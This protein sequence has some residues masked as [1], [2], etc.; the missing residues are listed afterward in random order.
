MQRYNLY[1]KDIQR[2]IEDIEKSVKE[3][4]ISTFSKSRDTIDSNA[5]RIQI[6]GESLKNLPLNNWGNFR[7]DAK[8]FIDFRNIISHAYFK[9]N[10]HILWDIIKN[11][12]PILKKQIGIIIKEIKN[13][14]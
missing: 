11:K 10:P 4:D 12:I 5:M 2:A 14:K 9:I 8:S 7:Q 1:L 6:I 13:E 3:I